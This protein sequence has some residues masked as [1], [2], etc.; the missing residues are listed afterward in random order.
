MS[1]VSASAPGAAVVDL[2]IGEWRL[3]VRGTELRRDGGEAVKLEPK[4]AEVLALLA[5]RPGEV[6]GRED[7]LSAAWPGVVVGDDTLTQAII[8][9]RKALGDD[10]HAPKYIETISKRGYRLIAPVTAARQGAGAIAIAPP[11]RRRGLLLGTLAAILALALWLTVPRMPWPLGS[12]SGAGPAA[13]GIPTVA[14]LPLANLSGDPKREYFSDGVTEDIINAL[15]R[16]SGVRVMSRNAVQGLKGKE[17]SVQAIRDEL[18]ARYIVEGSL[19]E[20]D[21][22]LRV[23]VALSDG[24]GGAQLWSERYQGEGAQLFEIQDQIV[25]H[26]V[27]ALHVKLNQFEQQ[28]GFT[29]PAA[30]LEAHDLVLR[31]RWLLNRTKR[32][33][34]RE[35]RESLARAALLAPEYAEIYTEMGM[36]EFQRVNNGWV[37]DAAAAMRRAEE[38]GKRALATFD[39]RAHAGAHSL[40]AALYSHQERFP[41]ALAHAEKAN[42]LNPS[43]SMALYWRGNALMCVGR[44][45][46]AIAVLE[47]ARRFEPYPMSGQGVIL[48]MAYYVAGRY[49]DALVQADALLV[50]VPEQ[51][52]LHALRAATL[53]QMDKPDE[54]RQAA[55]QV[56]RLN[57]LFDPESYAT[58]FADPKY[59]AAFREGLRKAGL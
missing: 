24:E 10:A 18:G 16:F 35:A 28:R 56:R 30:S 11:P 41:E 22:K 31:A 3:D 40:L 20:A 42:E 44:I 37:E 58:F 51:G 4:A 43:D 34:N 29:R 45:E 2:Q 26:I 8:K 7:L 50:R 53:A 1:K 36:A 17:L 25:K 55:E 38:L 6:I 59:T 12:D 27:G 5:A 13:T 32:D 48:G 14:I 47:T 21:G 52:Y 54:A 46:E 15:A 57:P 39:T 33:A 23:T 19:R 9:L 49:P